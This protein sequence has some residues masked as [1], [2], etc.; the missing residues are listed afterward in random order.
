MG[1]TCFSDYLLIMP[2]KSLQINRLQG[3]EA[4]DHLVHLP[5]LKGRNPR[6]GG[7]ALSRLLLLLVPSLPVRESAEWNPGQ[8]SGH[9]TL[10]SVMKSP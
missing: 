7:K 1:N 5:H 9:R 4:G 8:T 2:P 3:R 10:Y 6:R